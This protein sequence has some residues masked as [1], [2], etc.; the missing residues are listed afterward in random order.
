MK[1]T[2]EIEGLEELK[3][4]FA[5]ATRV[6]KADLSDMS[7]QAAEAGVKEAKRNHPYT[8]RTHNLTDEAFAAPAID[9]QGQTVADMVWPED[10][11]S[12]VNKGT[13]RSKAYPFTPQ[14]EERA[15]QA[16]K[17]GVDIAVAHFT[18]RIESH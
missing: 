3:H 18:D 15:E 2:F 1:L 4:E 16:L 7:L 6:L 17:S 10:Y 13:S 11:A 9:R 8:D 14:A 12:F 5:Q